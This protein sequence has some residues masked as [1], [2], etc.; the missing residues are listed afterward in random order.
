[1]EDND[2]ESRERILQQADAL[3]DQTTPNKIAALAAIMMYKAVKASVDAGDLPRSTLTEHGLTVVLLH[4]LFGSDN[5]PGTLE[6]FG[7][8]VLDIAEA[9]EVPE[10]KKPTSKDFN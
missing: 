9:M 3:L 7:L 5:V 4:T 8:P 10:P 1:M 6:L 2:D